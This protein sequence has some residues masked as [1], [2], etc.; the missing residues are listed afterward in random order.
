MNLKKIITIDGPAG[1]GKSTLARELAQRLKWTYLDTGALYR[2]LAVQALRQGVDPNQ[3]TQAEAL[4]REI[5][6]DLQPQPQGTVIIVNGKDLTASL[7]TPEISQ[8]ASIISAWPG[9]RVALLDLQKSW[10][11]RGK[12]VAEGRDMGTVVFPEAGLK[13][14][15]VATPEIRAQRRHA[16]LAGKGETISLE[17]VLTQVKCRDQADENRTV[18]PLKAADEALIIDSS[19]LSI[20]EIMVIMLKNFYQHFG[21]TVTEP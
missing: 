3:Q 15:L 6:I 8:Q 5:E 4:A 19:H 20:T 18:A 16:E 12:V 17:E 11:V 7:R 2:A 1:S 14:F 9:V 13:F 10:G 21:Q